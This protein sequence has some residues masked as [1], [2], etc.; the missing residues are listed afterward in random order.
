VKRVVFELQ[1]HGHDDE[2]ALHEAA[3]HAALAHGAAA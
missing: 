2:K 3:Q 1:P